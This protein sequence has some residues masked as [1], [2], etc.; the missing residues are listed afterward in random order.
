VVVGEQHVERDVGV[1]HPH[2]PTLRGRKYEEHPFS[3]A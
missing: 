3:W 2:A 1:V